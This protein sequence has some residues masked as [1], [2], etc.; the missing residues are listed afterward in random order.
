M[1]KTNNKINKLTDEELKQVNG[2]IKLDPE[3]L[4]KKV[5]D[6]YPTGE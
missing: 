1:K 5:E 2:G 6:K 4:R 3:R